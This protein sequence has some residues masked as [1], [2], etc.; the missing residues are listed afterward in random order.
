MT[1]DLDS[2]RIPLGKTSSTLRG[3][4]GAVL[5]PGS[6]LIQEPKV[7]APYKH[8]QESKYHRSI[9]AS[10]IRKLRLNAVVCRT[11]CNG[12]K[13][14]T[15]IQVRIVLE[16][17]ES[18]SPGRGGNQPQ[19]SDHRGD[20]KIHNAPNVTSAI[21]LLKKQVDNEG[22]YTVEEHHDSEEDVEL[23]GGS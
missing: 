7:S 11:S 8:V 13:Q 23:G 9:K 18:L 2:L 1:A 22:G 16:I 10:K 15:L 20:Y 6:F 14:T 17:D 3:S 21:Q 19:E 12:F 4:L 5:E